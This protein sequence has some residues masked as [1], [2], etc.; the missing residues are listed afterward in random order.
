MQIKNPVELH[1]VRVISSKVEQF[2]QIIPSLAITR[3]HH[4]VDPTD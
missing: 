4:V 1:I 2:V 3:Q